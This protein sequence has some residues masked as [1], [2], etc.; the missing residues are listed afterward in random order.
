MIF[1]FQLKKIRVEFM[2]SRFFDGFFF[3]II[4]LW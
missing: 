1:F 4:E 2:W 3:N